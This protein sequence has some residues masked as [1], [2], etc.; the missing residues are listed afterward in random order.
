MEGHLDIR[1]VVCWRWVAGNGGGQRWSLELELHVI[2]CEINCVSVQMMRSSSK[3][4]SPPRCE[5]FSE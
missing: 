5:M 1:S 2:I 3:L 4:Y